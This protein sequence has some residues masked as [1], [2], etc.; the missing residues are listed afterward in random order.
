MNNEVLSLLEIKFEIRT[1][2][3]IEYIEEILNEY[4]KQLNLDEST[5]VYGKGSKKSTY[6]RKYET[7]YSPFFYFYLFLQKNT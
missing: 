4:K 6:Q 2:Y 7:F 3:A 1:E 5:F